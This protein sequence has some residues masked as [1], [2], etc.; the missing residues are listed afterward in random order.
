MRCFGYL[1]L[2]NNF[3]KVNIFVSL[4]Y[5]IILILI[6]FTVSPHFLVDIESQATG[7]SQ[8]HWLRRR[9]SGLLACRPR[10]GGLE[11]MAHPSACNQ[12]ANERTRDLSLQCASVAL[13]LRMR[14][15]ENA[16]PGLESATL[17]SAHAACGHTHIRVCGPQRAPTSPGVFNC[18]QTPTTGDWVSAGDAGRATSCATI[19]RQRR[20]ATAA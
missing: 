9:A 14:P 17:L 10:A 5:Q 13:V 11:R 16:G 1:L 19:A 2:S 15:R 3:K 8:N 20:R 12:S 7:G 4:T 6:Y 18:R